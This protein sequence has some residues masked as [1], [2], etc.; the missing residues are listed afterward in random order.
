MSQAMKIVAR[1]LQ[2]IAQV[3]DALDT[4][5]VHLARAQARQQRMIEEMRQEQ[6]KRRSK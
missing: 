6:Q 1:K 3:A 5:A 4:T 2:E